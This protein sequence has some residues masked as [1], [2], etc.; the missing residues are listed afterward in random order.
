MAML[1]RGQ[2]YILKYF[3]FQHHHPN[4]FTLTFLPFISFFPWLKYKSVHGSALLIMNYELLI[5]NYQFPFPFACF[6]NADIA[7]S[8]TLCILNAYTLIK[9]IFTIKIS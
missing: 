5:M 4:H 8:L 2:T 6:C 9:I 1:T 7:L 3:G